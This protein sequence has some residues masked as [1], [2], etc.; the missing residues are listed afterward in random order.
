MVEINE[1]LVIHTPP[2]APTLPF[3]NLGCGRIHLPGERPAHH[4]FVPLDIYAGREWLN[5]DRSENVGADRTFDLF[6][7]PWPLE[8][9]S[10]G[11]ALLS[12][13]C[14]HIP[15][16]IKLHPN[17]FGWSNLIPEINA[18]V[19]CLSQLQD[20]WFAFFAE[21]YRVLTHDARVHILSPHLRSDGAFIDPTHTRYLT[22]MS[23]YHSMRSDPNAPFEYAT[24]GIHFEIEGQPLYEVN[25]AFHHLLAQPD[26]PP[27]V[28][29]SKEALFQHEMDTRWNVVANFY[30]Q[31]RAVKE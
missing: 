19:K 18:R 10:Y 31:L 12:H 4:A 2:Q 7:Y 23:F 9:D 25:S 28:R 27:T 29:A 17:A 11:G 14:E 20:S 15:H 16:E 24:G 13:L 8:S 1:P 21:L 30:I 5:I 26:D 6:S 3:L 22:P